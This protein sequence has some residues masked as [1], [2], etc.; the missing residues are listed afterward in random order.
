MVHN[1]PKLKDPSLLIE[2]AFVNGEFVSAASGETF[3][4][5]DPATGKKIAAAPEFNRNDTEKAIE[6]AVEAYKTVNKKRF[7]TWTEVLEVVEQ[8]GYRKVQPRSIVLENVLEAPIYVPQA[9]A[10]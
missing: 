7:P 3:D 6:A 9:E 10:A 2:K 8:L 5:H 4:V 1:V